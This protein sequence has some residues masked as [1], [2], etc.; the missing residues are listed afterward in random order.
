MSVVIDDFHVVGVTVIPSEADAPLIVDPDAVLAFALTLQGFQPIG[1]RNAQIIQHAGVPQHAQLAA[2]HRLDI[3]RQ[4][5]GRRSAPDPF[6]FLV[7]KVPDHEPTIT[8][9]VI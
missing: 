9:T 2:C 4:A 8:L 1:R 7:S 3:D 6:R 5:P